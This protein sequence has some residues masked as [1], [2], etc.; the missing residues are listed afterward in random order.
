[1]KYKLK[2][3]Y[4]YDTITNTY[5][6]LAEMLYAKYSPTASVMNGMIYI[7]GGR[8]DTTKIQV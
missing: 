3:V 4:K 6:N 8:G 1:M 7:S 5:S 2:A